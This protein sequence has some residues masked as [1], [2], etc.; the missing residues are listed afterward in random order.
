MVVARAWAEAL[1]TATCDVSLAE[2]LAPDVAAAAINAL[3]VAI[4]GITWFADYHITMRDAVCVNLC[5]PGIGPSGHYCQRVACEF[6]KS[7]AIKIVTIE[8]L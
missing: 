2:S 6:V 7:N 1:M 5:A 4:S 3:K 8:F